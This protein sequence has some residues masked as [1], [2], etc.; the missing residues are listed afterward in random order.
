MDIELIKKNEYQNKGKYVHIYYDPLIDMWIA[1]GYS[2]YSLRV[3]AK[4]RRYDNLRGHSRELDMPCTLI[5]NSAMKMIRQSVKLLEE[6][7]DSYLYIERNN[8]FPINDYV[9]WTSK[10]AHEEEMKV[11][12]NI[13]TKVSEFVPRDR[14]IPDSMST[15]AKYIKHFGDRL[16]AFICLVVF[17]PLFL[18]C[19][20]KIKREDGGPAIFKQERIGRFGK[21]FYI[22]KFR[23]MRL[24]AEKMGPQLSHSGGDNDP[25]LTKT[26]AFI[27]AHHLDELPQLW[28]VF[29][30]D[31]AFV[32]YRPERKFYIDQIMEYDKRYSY[33]YQIRPGVTSYATLYNGYTDTMEKMLQRLEYD[34]YYLSKRSWYFD[35]KILFNTFCSIVFGKKF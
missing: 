3:F 30:G 5:T 20:I 29:I 9:R 4:E 7:P 11:G 21:P 32:G 35:A 17:S 18:I 14:F 13:K 33:L 26:G 6:I 22:Y 23:S 12:M 8:Q 10:L 19:Y 34:L 31:M 24:D 25:R 16:I 2:A 15:F 27:R 28:N 1:Y